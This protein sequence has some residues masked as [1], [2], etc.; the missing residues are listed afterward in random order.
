M[1]GLLPSL[2]SKIFIDLDYIQL[3]SLQSLSKFFNKFIHETPELFHYKLIQN[4]H[5]RDHL[6]GEDTT[7]VD[8]LVGKYGIIAGPVDY[9]WHQ[10]R[11]MHETSGRKCYQ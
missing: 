2:L 9:N 3:C 7:I 10:T 4:P 5:I 8:N 6:S 1:D 11:M